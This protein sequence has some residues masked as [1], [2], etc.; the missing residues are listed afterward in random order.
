[1]I[2]KHEKSGKNGDDFRLRDGVSIGRGVGGIIRECAADV[3]NR[4]VGQG[5]KYQ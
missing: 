1:M 3:A 5:G 2:V 4:S